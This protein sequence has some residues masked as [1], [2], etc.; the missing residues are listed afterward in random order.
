[1]R[2]FI[3]NHE[4]DTGSFSSIIAINKDG[5][6]LGIPYNEENV[7]YQN[8]LKWLKEENIPEEWTNAD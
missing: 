2:Y 3:W 6:V 8:Y 1:M 5:Q 4:N 7:D